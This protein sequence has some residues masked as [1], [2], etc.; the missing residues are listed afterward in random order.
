[1]VLKKMTEKVLMD[2]DGLYSSNNEHTAISTE[3]S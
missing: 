2:L 1:M 3:R